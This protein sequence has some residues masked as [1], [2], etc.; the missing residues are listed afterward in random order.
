MSVATSGCEQAGEIGEG[1][2][3]GGRG[4]G[5][6]W[7]A[8]DGGDGDARCGH[9]EDGHDRGSARL[10]VA[11]LAHGVLLVGLFDGGTGG[12]LAPAD[13]RMRGA[14]RHG[15]AARTSYQLS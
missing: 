4:P 13:M 8:S 2:R 1:D 6:A 14:C 7:A 9:Y 12:T 15:G 10:T 5:D 3:Y 11:L